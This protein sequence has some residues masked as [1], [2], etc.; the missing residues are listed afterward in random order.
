MTTQSK[1]KPYLYENS[2]GFSVE[3]RSWTNLMYREADRKMYISSSKVMKQASMVIYADS[4]T[5]WDIP[6][7]FEPITKEEKKRIIR[8]IRE[9]FRDIGC[10]LYVTSGNDFFKNYTTVLEALM[11]ADD[12]AAYLKEYSKLLMESVPVFEDTWARSRLQRPT[13][14]STK[15]TKLRPNYYVSSDGFSLETFFSRSVKLTYCEGDHVLVIGGEML[16]GSIPF[17]IYFNEYNKWNPPYDTE[18]ITN[19]KRL[20][21]IE[22]IREVCRFEGLEIDVM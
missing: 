15:I 21:I 4:I 7:D 19:E 11:K 14:T 12:K 2:K 3:F 8:N 6:H 1:S 22:N 10:K 17:V 13:P 9:V 5:R 16:T 20:H 18:I